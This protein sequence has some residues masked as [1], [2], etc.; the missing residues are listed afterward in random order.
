MENESSFIAK[1]KSPQ[2]ARKETL[3]FLGLPTAFCPNRTKLVLKL[4]LLRHSIIF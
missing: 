3:D 1:E 4:I 2:K